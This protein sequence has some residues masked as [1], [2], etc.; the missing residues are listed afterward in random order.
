M[1]VHPPDKASFFQLHHFVDAMDSSQHWLAAVVKQV[2][3][4][5]GIL[6]RFDGWSNKW[7]EWLSLRSARLAPFRRYSRGYGGQESTALRDWS[8]EES[9]LDL[10]R[11][12]L[13]KVKGGDLSEFPNPYEITQYFRGSLFTLVDNLLGNSL[14]SESV[15]TVLDFLEEVLQFAV[16]WLQGLPLRYPALYQGLTNPDLYLTDADCAFA[17][18]WPELFTTVERILGSDPRLKD[19]LTTEATKEDLESRLTTDERLPEELKAEP[20]KAHFVAVF[21]KL[22]GIEVVEKLISEDGK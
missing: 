9:E 15:L 16:W 6:V 19:L 10:H 21:L 20:V 3:P 4:S 13:R 2:D 14:P 17:E 11:A 7:N 8:F 1:A 22:G 12:T 18:I 5:K